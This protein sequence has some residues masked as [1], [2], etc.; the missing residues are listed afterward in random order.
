MNFPVQGNL[1]LHVEK[2]VEIDGV[3]MGVLTD[4]TPYL[5][6]RGLARLCGVESSTIVRMGAEWLEDVQRPRI[7]KIKQILEQRSLSLASPYIQVDGNTYWT[8]AVCLAV[9][10][11]YA[12]DASQSD[13]AIA[14][15]HFRTLAGRGFQEFVYAQVGYDPNQ[16]IDQQWQKYH[17][18]VSLVYNSVP[19]GYFGIFKEIADMIVTLGQNGLYTDE[20]FVPDI[21]VGRIWSGHWTGNNLEQVFGPRIKYEHNFPDYYPQAAANPQEPW[22][23]PEAALGEFRKWFREVYIDKG[24]FATYLQNQEKAKA[25]PPAFSQQAIE[26]FTKKNNKLN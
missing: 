19:N 7:T 16:R 25:L 23:Y 20:K 13:S 4:G 10:E 24:K 5:T 6:S 12:F 17:D 21:S 9:L 11:Y 8:G 14:L 18:R 22:C 26:A 1:D 3:G 15:Q 2:E